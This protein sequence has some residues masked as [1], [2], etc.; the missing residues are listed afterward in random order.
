MDTK[1][2][3]NGFFL[4]SSSPGSPGRVVLRRR[5]GRRNR[6]SAEKIR[7]AL[8]RETFLAFRGGQRTRVADTVL[9]GFAKFLR[10]ALA[11]KNSILAPNTTLFRRKIPL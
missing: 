2:R 5:R 10:S 1:I 3:I 11:T 4:S 6:R 8:A 7:A 9:L